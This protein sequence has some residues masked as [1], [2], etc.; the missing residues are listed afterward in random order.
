[1]DKKEILLSIIAY[2]L[3]VKLFDE[4]GEDIWFTIIPLYALLFL[5]PVFVVLSIVIDQQSE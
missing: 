3:I 5:L 4:G 1:M 2:T